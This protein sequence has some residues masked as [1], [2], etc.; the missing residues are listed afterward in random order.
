[1]RELPEERQSGSSAWTA[2]VGIAQRFA[3][4]LLKAAP[5]GGTVWVARRSLWIWQRATRNDLG[6]IIFRGSLIWRTPTPFF[7]YPHTPSKLGGNMSAK[8]K[9]HPPRQERA[10]DLRRTVIACIVQ[11]LQ[12]MDMEGLRIILTMAEKQIDA[13]KE[14]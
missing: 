9:K 13:Q 8:S 1:M 14:A 5:C 7:C 4:A 12:R 6:F 10:D 2:A 11:K 3:G